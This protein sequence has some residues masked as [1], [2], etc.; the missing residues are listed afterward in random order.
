MNPKEE[1]CTPARLSPFPA[2]KLAGSPS[3]KSK[4]L[5]MPGLKGTIS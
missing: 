3:G 2:E 5:P 1:K 4:V